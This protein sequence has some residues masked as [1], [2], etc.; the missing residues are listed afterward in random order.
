MS[1]SSSSIDGNASLQSMESGS[2]GGCAPGRQKQN[3]SR[4]KHWMNFIVFLGH[5]VQTWMDIIHCS[6]A[7]FQTFATYLKDEAKKTNGSQ[8]KPGTAVEFL[9]TAKETMF[10]KYPDHEIFQEKVLD[11]WYP[12]LRV[13]LEKNIVREFIRRG[14]C[15]Y[16]TSLPIGLNLLSIICQYYLELGTPDAM[17]RRASL[18]ATFGAI[19]RGGE[20]ALTS[21]KILGL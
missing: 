14:E 6:I 15:P 3:D 7:I 5:P 17:M 21:W 8:Y 16:D 10:T 19:G 1:S 18:I 20:V 11:T 13:A 2:R 9:S 12:Q 4:I